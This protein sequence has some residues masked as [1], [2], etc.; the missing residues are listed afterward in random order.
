METGLAQGG[1]S[2]TEPTRREE[3]SRGRGER[4]GYSPEKTER[5]RRSSEMQKEG[6][7]DHMMDRISFLSSVLTPNS[8]VS[9]D[10]GF[11]LGE[12]TNP[13]III[14]EPC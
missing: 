2:F 10:G 6:W 9:S 8:S 3:Q 4:K 7:H 13:D 14:I 5:S 11:A 12:Y 1:D